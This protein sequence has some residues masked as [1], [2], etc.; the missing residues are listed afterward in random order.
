MK[1]QT[2]D[3][4]DQVKDAF[5]EVVRAREDRE[6][7]INQARGYREDI[8]PKAQQTLDVSSRAYNVG[9]VDFLTLID[10]WRQ[11][12]R[13]EVNYHRLEASLRQTLAELERVVGGMNI[14]G[15]EAISVP[16]GDMIPIPEE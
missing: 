4:P 12:L 13:Y 16:D 9:E 14:S 6:K 1:L 10:N 11:V 5:A 7:L 8:L 3:P 2:V 15:T